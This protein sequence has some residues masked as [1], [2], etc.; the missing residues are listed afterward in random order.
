[1]LLTF[2]CC[3]KTE[4]LKHVAPAKKVIRKIWFSTAFEISCGISKKSDSYL[5]EDGM[6]VGIIHFMGTLPDGRKA[7][8]LNIVNSFFTSLQNRR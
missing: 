7:A 3:G 4:I 1:M 8:T 2:F 6:Q 5:V